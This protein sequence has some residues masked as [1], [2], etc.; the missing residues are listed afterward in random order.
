MLHRIIH[1]TQVGQLLVSVGATNDADDDASLTPAVPKLDL[2]VTYMTESF[3]PL[4][5][6][7]ELYIAIHNVMAI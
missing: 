7:L 6:S 4:G 5:H 3:H 2:T 1:R